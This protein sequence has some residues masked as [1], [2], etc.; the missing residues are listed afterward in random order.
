MYL[1]CFHGMLALS[2]SVPVP[3][4][5]ESGGGK[6]GARMK[7]PVTSGKLKQHLTYNWWKYL[8]IAVVAFGLVDLLYTVTAYRP[9]RDKT[10]NLY[11]YGYVNESALTEYMDNVR[12][13]EMPDMEQVSFVT[14]LDDDTY[15]PMQLMTYISAQEGDVFLL[16]RD[17]FL[18]Y[19]SS[20]AFLPLEDDE[21]LMG[22]FNEAGIDLRR[23]WRTLADSDET[24][25]Y[26]IPADMLPGLNAL[27]YADNG[28][29]TVTVYNG[30]QENVMKFLRILCRDMLIAPETENEDP[31]A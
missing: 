29:L 23:G 27:C 10:V 15:G 30:N 6:I 16:T 24:H 8:L 31:A 21:E 25:L 7:T 19:A 18:S 22:I 11:V 17:E 13:A 20:G 28:F 2:V 12:Q 9:S 4:R 26:G 5:T 3:L 14:L 1:L